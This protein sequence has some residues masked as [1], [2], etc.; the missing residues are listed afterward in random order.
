MTAPVCCNPD[1]VED[2][3]KHEAGFV[4]R[5]GKTREGTSVCVSYHNEV[6]FVGDQLKERVLWHVW[7]CTG[8]FQQF[9]TL[10]Q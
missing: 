8:C 1:C 7:Q 10:A 3:K 4:K 5:V 2:R 9:Q 6:C